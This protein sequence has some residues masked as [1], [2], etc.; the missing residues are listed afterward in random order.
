MLYEEKY[1]TSLPTRASPAGLS[2]GPHRPAL[3]QPPRRAP[4][5]PDRVNYTSQRATARE[6]KQ[7]AKG[8]DREH[9][10]PVHMA[11]PST[12]LHPYTSLNRL[13]FSKPWTYKRPVEAYVSGGHHGANGEKAVPPPPIPPT[14]R[15]TADGALSAPSSPLASSPPPPPCLSRAD[16]EMDK[17]LH[18]KQ[19]AESE[20][21]VDMA[22]HLNVKMQEL[23]A[24]A[25]KVAFTSTSHLAHGLETRH[26]SRLLV[27]GCKHLCGVADPGL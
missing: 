26:A 24:L 3:P 12:L 16:V 15:G 7:K 25:E 10:M 17:L 22:N 23:D 19:G 11:H 6:V 8:A 4:E 9:I 5:D 1:P 20:A 21:A 18:S 27:K 13:A 2:L 14:P